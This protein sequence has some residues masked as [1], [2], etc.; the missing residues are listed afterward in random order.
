MSSNPI[1]PVVLCG[2]AGTRL[3]PLSRKNYPK[4]F[5]KVGGESLIAQTVKRAASVPGCSD[6]LLVSNEAYQFLL[7]DECNPVL[8]GNGVVLNQI[9]EP[10]GRN[11]A[12]AIALAALWAKAKFPNANPVLLVLPA[13][14]LINP[15]AAF[16]DAAAL[17][18]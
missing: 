14:H 3:W 13:D 16:V 15:V 2:G 10:A 7:A 8:Q 5:L 18:I 17:A 9:L 12:P 6:L 11:T 4:P 1:I